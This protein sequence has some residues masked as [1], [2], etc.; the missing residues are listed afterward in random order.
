MTDSTAEPTVQHPSPSEVEQF[1]AT[2]RRSVERA[3][4]PGLAAVEAVVAANRPQR[5]RKPRAPSFGTRVKAV[6]KAGREPV[7]EPDGTITTI[8]PSDSEASTAPIGRQNGNGAEIN[9]S[10]EDVP[11]YGEDL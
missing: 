11:N 5:T 2:I 1:R 6:I 7:I 10:W 8:K 3:F 4:Y 9:P